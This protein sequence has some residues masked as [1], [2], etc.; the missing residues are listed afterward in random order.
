MGSKINAIIKI[1]KE[2]IIIFISKAL[3]FRLPL[4]WFFII[5]LSDPELEITAKTPVYMFNKATVPNISGFN[6]FVKIIKML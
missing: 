6:S 5:N 1:M 3:N 2:N 4:T